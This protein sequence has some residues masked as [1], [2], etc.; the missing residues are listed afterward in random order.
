M[1]KGWCWLVKNGWGG[2][3]AAVTSNAFWL[4]R[5]IWSSHF[6]N[7]GV[8]ELFLLPFFLSASENDSCS[9]KQAVSQWHHN[10]FKSEMTSDWGFFLLLFVSLS[11]L[12]VG[13]RTWKDNKNVYPLSAWQ[14][15]PWLKGQNGGTE[16]RQLLSWK[17]IGQR[18]ITKIPH[19]RLLSVFVDKRTWKHVK[20]AVLVNKSI[21]QMLR[22][23]EWK[24]HLSRMGVMWCS[25]AN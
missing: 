21:Q 22:K 4:T 16:V 23:Y 15:L 10:L 17:R 2:W 9:D 11:L 7:E 13:K 18:S 24:T 3:R 6:Q 1:Q 14:L 19:V 20:R 8:R 25:V 5:P 12:M